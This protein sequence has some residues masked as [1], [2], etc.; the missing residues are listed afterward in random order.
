[1]NKGG[2]EQNVNTLGKERAGQWPA[3]F[4]LCAGVLCDR[5][6]HIPQ[7]AVKLGAFIDTDNRAGCLIASPSVAS[8]DVTALT[9]LDCI[10]LHDVEQVPSGCVLVRRP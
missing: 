7:G 5:D 4:S 2:T 3:L 6:G 8:H 1:V 9:A 10:F